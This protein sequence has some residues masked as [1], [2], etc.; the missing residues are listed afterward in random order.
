L[1]FEDEEAVSKMMTMMEDKKLQ[2]EFPMLAQ[3]LQ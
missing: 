2:D 3:V 1:K